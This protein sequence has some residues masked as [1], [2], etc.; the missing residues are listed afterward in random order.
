MGSNLLDLYLRRR[1]VA[2]ACVA[3]ADGDGSG[4][5][6]RT[7]GICDKVEQRHFCRRAVLVYGIDGGEGVCGEIDDL[8][9]VVWAHR[10]GHDEGRVVDRPDRP[11]AEGGLV[12]GWRGKRIVV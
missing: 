11:L 2:L 4:V 1:R 8:R 5:C 9:R 12:G 3:T 7:S 6:R 10:F